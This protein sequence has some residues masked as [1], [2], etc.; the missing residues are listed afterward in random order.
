M[1]KRDPFELLVVCKGIEGR[2]GKL[3][4][5]DS[6]PVRIM[7]V[8]NLT[9]DSFYSGSIRKTSDEVKAEALRMQQEGADI[10][11]LGARS[12][13]PYKKFE[14]PVSVEKKVLAEA[15]KIVCRFVD[16]PVSADTTR[17]EPAKTALEAG[18]TAL[19]EVYGLTGK[20][21]GKMAGLVA[22]KECALMLTAHESKPLRARGETPIERVVAALS[23]S[24]GF[25][26]DRGISRK[27]I[28]V[29]PG[30]GFFK[31]EDISNI[32]WNC[33]VIED[34]E[35][36]RTLG[37]SICVGVS[38]KRFL[39]QLV[40]DKPPE[41]RL[42]ASL[43]AS[44]ISIYNGAHMIRTHDVRETLEVATVAKALQEKRIYSMRPQT[45]I[46][47]IFNAEERF[48]ERRR[49]KKGRRDA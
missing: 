8:I 19:N 12:T 40:G 25:C 10:I 33:S 14:I 29:D 1:K 49:D 9:S 41:A 30:I 15:V 38:R 2:I 20:D 45:E 7:G 18:A 44:A 34:L 4:V 47:E 5:G 43:A 22:S 3:R 36:L 13:A 39:G 32:E 27:N 42:N 28:I 35:M 48:S 16:I 37:Q 31:D 17:F 11:D 6:Y 26:G 24:L 23:R 21:A 46:A